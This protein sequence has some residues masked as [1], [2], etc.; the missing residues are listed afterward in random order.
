M[1]ILIGRD[2]PAYLYLRVLLLASPGLL[3]LRPSHLLYTSTS[4]KCRVA[5]E[6][7]SSSTPPTGEAHMA[8]YLEKEATELTP[9]SLLGFESLGWRFKCLPSAYFARINQAGATTG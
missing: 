7:F 3:V 1:L 6:G 4:G 5:H 8:R 2:W 9:T